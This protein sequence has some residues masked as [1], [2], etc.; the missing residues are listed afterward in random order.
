MSQIILR[1]ILAA[2]LVLQFGCQTSQSANTLN[3]KNPHRLDTQ[4]KVVNTQPIKLLP[5]DDASQD[6]SFAEFRSQLIKAAR[7]HEAKFVISIL[8]SDIKNGS[9]AE[10]GIMQFKNQ[11][12]VDQRDSNLWEV[13]TTI[14]IMG[15]SF[16]IN[17]GAREF[18]APYV[19]S[20]WPSV[21]SQLPQN[22]DPLDYQV[23]VDK[24]V[25]VKSQP[26]S[27]ATTVSVLSYDVVKLSSTT[28]TTAPNSVNSLNWM[29]ISTLAGQEGYVQDK[30]VRG[31]S[32]FHACFRKLGQ[33]WL[34]TELAALE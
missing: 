21:V 14:L 31:A 24:E 25:A 19:T 30:Y 4:T 34:M 18:C 3:E 7:N 28:V 29:K 9:D 15:G 13:L 32:D 11:W 17:D 12:Q 2:M 26:N 10:R 16:R 20:E 8:D 22:A 5:V 1:F 33:K 6:P 23:I 27:S